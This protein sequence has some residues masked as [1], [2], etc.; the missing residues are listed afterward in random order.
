[1]LYLFRNSLEITQ[2]ECICVR[3]RWVSVCAMSREQSTLNVR[4]SSLPFSFNCCSPLRIFRFLFDLTFI[5]QQ[6]AVRVRERHS[7]WPTPCEWKPFVYSVYP[8]IRNRNVCMFTR[9]TVWVC[10]LKYLCVWV[11]VCTDT[12]SQWYINAREC[13]RKKVSMRVRS[14]SGTH[15]LE[16]ALTINDIIIVWAANQTRLPQYDAVR[17]GAKQ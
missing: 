3:H 4:R 14:F 1:M 15:T 10:V 2:T 9:A 11:S 8:D 17:V 7:V 5:F 6:R 13:A 16:S 12:L